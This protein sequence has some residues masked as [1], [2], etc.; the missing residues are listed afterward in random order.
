MSESLP[1]SSPS[2]LMAFA[3]TIIALAVSVTSFNLYVSLWSRHKVLTSMYQVPLVFL[4]YIICMFVT[5][6]VPLTIVAELHGMY[7]TVSFFTW[8]VCYLGYAVYRRH[9]LKR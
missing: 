7:R 6:V 3:V 9:I 1:M 2:I 8:I 4:A 5:I